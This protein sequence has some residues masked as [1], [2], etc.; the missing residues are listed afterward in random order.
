M[1]IKENLVHIQSEMALACEKSLRNISQVELLAVTKT[2]TLKQI[3]T[4]HQLGLKHFAEN[5]LPHVK[6]MALAMEGD[7]VVWHFI[8]HLQRNK[9]KE[10]LQYCEWVQSVD[11]IRLIE[12]LQQ[13]ASTLD[14][15]I[16]ILLQINISGETQKTG[17]SVEEIEEAVARVL[18]CSH[19]TLRGLMCMAPHVDNPEQS[20]LVFTQC[21]E[22]FELIKQRYAVGKSF[23]T[24]SMGMSN[25]YPVAI[26]CGS[27]QVRIGSLL[28]K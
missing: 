27:T 8:G 26:S 1:G 19:L 20:R 2:A 25:D 22:Q 21:A 28:F 7:N 5:R 24:L 17:L 4:L 9:V 14:K 3:Q 6:E 10:V 15:Q 11:S 23:D 13:E 18:A 16:N 12:K